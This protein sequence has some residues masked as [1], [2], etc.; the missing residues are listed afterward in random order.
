MIKLKKGSQAAKNYMAKIR[1][2]RKGVKK[3]AKKVKRKLSGNPRRETQ[4]K[5]TKSHNVNI[6]VLSG[7]KLNI[8]NLL[9]KPFKYNGGYADF[10]TY[11]I[12]KLKDT[13]CIFFQ[14]DTNKFDYFAN[15]EK[16]NKNFFTAFNYMYG[17]KNKFKLYFKDI[18]IID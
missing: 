13:Y 12:F 4:H 15:I 17:K 6:R 5:D 8:D 7:V 2:M 14:T 1:A 9:N 18:V 16:I 3:A 11:K 10:R